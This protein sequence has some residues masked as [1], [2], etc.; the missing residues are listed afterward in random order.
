MMIGLGPQ[1]AVDG[2][3]FSWRPVRAS[4]RPGWA[5]LADVALRLEVTLASEA[6][7]ERTNGRIRRV[8]GSHGQS[9]RVEVLQARV[10]LMGGA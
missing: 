9:M 5:E 8:Y 2:N 6:L 3:G 1:W 10:T 7:T 4:K